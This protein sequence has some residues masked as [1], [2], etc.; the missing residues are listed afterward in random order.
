MIRLDKAADAFNTIADSTVRNALFKYH[1]AVK[2]HLN[3]HVHHASGNAG[4]TSVAKNE[5]AGTDTGDDYP[6]PA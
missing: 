4:Y 3:N 6:F 1:E 2:D 5:T